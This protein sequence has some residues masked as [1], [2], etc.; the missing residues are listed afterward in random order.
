MGVISASVGPQVGPHAL[1]CLQKQL[2]HSRASLSV[3]ICPD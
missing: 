1:G 3:A 2:E